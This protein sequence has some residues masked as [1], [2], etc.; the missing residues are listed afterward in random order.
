MLSGP[1]LDTALY[2]DKRATKYQ[3]D[4]LV[5]IYSGQAGG[6]FAAVSNLIGRILGVKPASIEFGVDEKRRWLR[7]KSRSGHSGPDLLCCSRIQSC[8]RQ[9]KQIHAQ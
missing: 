3:N 9:I 1:K 4:S 5:A 2:I 6:F 7:I 8:N